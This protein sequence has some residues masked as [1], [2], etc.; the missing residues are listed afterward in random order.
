MIPND[1]P[2][3]RKEIRTALGRGLLIVLFLMTP[4]TGWSEHFVTGSSLKKALQESLAWNCTGTSLGS[5]LTALQQRTSV[6]IVLD[7]RIDPNRPITIST[8]LIPVRDILRMMTAEF[9]DLDVCF[10]SD[11][12]YVGPTDAARRLP[13]LID[14]TEEQLQQMRRQLPEGTVQPLTARQ[15]LTWPDVTEPRELVEQLTKPSG[16]LISHSRQIPHDL[17]ASGS[18]PETTRLKL[19]VLLLNQFDLRLQFSEDAAAFQ[20]ATIDPDASFERRYLIPREI[21]EDVQSEWE[22][23]VPEVKLRSSG[24]SHRVTTTLA[25]HARLT[26]ILDQAEWNR[27][28]GLSD[29]QDSLLNRK[30]ELQAAQAATLGTVIEHFRNNGIP[31]EVD[32]SNPAAVQAVL[33]RSVEIKVPRLPANEFFQQLFGPYFGSVIVQPR[34][35]I[36]RH[37]KPAP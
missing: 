10:S 1:R 15:S 4:S 11:F 35:V 2:S 3:H 28:S 27:E 18:L 22:Q 13:I 34:K 14:M 19:I 37:P 5:Q 7:R 36:L 26:A 23:T 31:I 6:C 29:G 30:L 21:R 8:P 33:Q 32:D 24:N 12:V 25:N 20:L 16:T 17:W 9:A